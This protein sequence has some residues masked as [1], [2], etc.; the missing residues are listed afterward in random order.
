MSILEVE[1][2]RGTYELTEI[3]ASP[4]AAVRPIRF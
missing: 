4:D 2:D 3:I 1:L